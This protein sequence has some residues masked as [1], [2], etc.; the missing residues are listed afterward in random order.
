MRRSNHQLL[1][2]VVAR[3][4]GG[5]MRY[6][7]RRL[8]NSAD[9]RDIAQETY[10]RLLRMDKVEVIRD[11]QAYVFRIAANL[12]YEFELAQRRERARLD[13]PPL[14]EDIERLTP[15]SPEEQADLA[16]HMAR[17]NKV[18]ER[19]SPKSRAALGCVQRMRSHRGAGHAKHV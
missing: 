2:E 16:A 6:L 3:F 13:E 7:R 19:L 10:A 15:M 1:N 14:A 4:S 17:L 8:R 9:A 18:M 11:P 12:A 5:L